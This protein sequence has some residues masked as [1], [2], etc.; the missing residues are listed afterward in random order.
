MMSV[1]EEN[2]ASAGRTPKGRRARRA[3]FA[4][5]LKV[6]ASRGFRGTSLD[7]IAA[8]ANLS[9]AAIRHHFA[10]REELFHEFFFSATVWL[11]DQLA[12]LLEDT[13]RRPEEV[14]QSAVRWHLEFIE[15]VD[16][17][18]W[19]EMSGY[20]IR[21]FQAKHSRDDFY[22]WVRNRYGDLIGRI[23]PALRAGERRN[24]AYTILTLV[25]GSW[26]THGRANTMR[27]VG[28]V[29]GQR[30]LLVAAAMDIATREPA[31]RSNTR[32]AALD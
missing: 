9:Q 19:L 14:L 28:S 31:G 29:R 2:F 8:A 23:N 32:S 5:T 6:M 18:I 24:R 21:S 22:R 25:L 3:I 20:W 27:D 16:T 12:G 15:E 7:A 30:E 17:T 26:I 4:A 13:A 1:I 10:T 11:R